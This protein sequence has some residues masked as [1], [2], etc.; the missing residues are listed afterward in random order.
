M[1]AVGANHNVACISRAVRAGNL[2]AVGEVFDAGDTLVDKN[3]LKRGFRKAG[4]Q[5][6]GQMVAA[7]D[8]WGI[9]KAASC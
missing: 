1:C 3:L 6:T 7:K 2:N 5:E 4:V 9:S 8:S